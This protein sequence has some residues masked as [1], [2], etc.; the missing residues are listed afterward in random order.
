VAA[1]RVDKIRCLIQLGVD[2]K[3]TDLKGNTFYHLA[4]RDGKT[5]VIQAFIDQV[6][7][8][9][10][11]SDG[12]TPLHLAAKFGHVD[13]VTLLLKKSKLDVRNK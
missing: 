12:D 2:I 1:D 8:T 7:L 3:T 10:V 4:A 5:A 9:S 6:D 11:N 13:V